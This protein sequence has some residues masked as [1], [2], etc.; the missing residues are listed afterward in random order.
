MK[1]IIVLLLVI[2][3]VSCASGGKAST[4]EGFYEV[5]LGTTKEELVKKLGK[6]NYIK[7]IGDNEE[8]YVYTE[9]LNVE[10]TTYEER[11]YYFTIKNGRVTSKNIK[12]DNVL[13]LDDKNSYEMQT[14][15]NRENQKD[16]EDKKPENG[17]FFFE[18]PF[19][20]QKKNREDE[21]N[22]HEDA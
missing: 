8:E 6:P 9:K 7:K 19:A 2:M 12:R 14:S 3:F 22:R 13:P 4:M 18:F 16:K 17:I 10:T 15:E 5:P 1:N 11:R 20:N 21:D